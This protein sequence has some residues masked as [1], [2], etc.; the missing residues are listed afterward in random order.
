MK[1]VLTFK[2]KD[3][4][5]GYTIYNNCKHAIGSYVKRSGVI[6]TGLEH[7]DLLREELEKALGLDLKPSSSFWDTFYVFL[8]DKNVHL[9]TDDNENK[10]KYYFLK[11]HKDVSFGYNDKKPNAKYVLLQAEEEAKEQNS[12]TR[13]KRRAITEFDKLTVD[14][15]RKALRLYGYNST[16]TSAEVVE[17]TLFKLVEEDPNKFLLVWVDNND[18]DTQFLIEEACSKGI[19]TKSKSTYKYGTD[20]IG[21]NIYDVIDYLNKIENRDL[22]LSIK[23]QLQSKDLTLG[24]QKVEFKRESSQVSKLLKEIEKEDNKKED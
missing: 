24:K 13:I 6:Y 22:K 4:W 5:S 11:G 17:S 1:A 16:N 14:Q 21:N 15:M 23:T 10:L 12:K 3:P 20:I 9:D 2:K 18:K 7:D 8:T 19:M